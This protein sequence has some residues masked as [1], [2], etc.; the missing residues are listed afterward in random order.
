MVV[1]DFAEERQTII[2]GAGPGGYVAA[3]R[4][5][6]LGQKVM[7]VEREHIGGVCLNVGCIPSKALISAGHRYQLAQ[8]E[9]FGVALGDATLDFA[10]TQDWKQNEVIN[11][12]TGGVEMLLKKHKVEIVRGEVYMHDDHTLRVL[13]ETSETA[14]QTYKFENLIL[15]TGS[16]PIEIPNFKFKGRVL[17]STGALA[18]PEVPKELV[19]I[20]GGYI[21]AELAG[22]YANL[23][24]HVTILEGSPAILPNFEKD[25]VDVVKKELKAKGID[26]HTK[27]LAKN[28]VQ[29]DDHVAV[30]YEIDGKEET[31]NADYCLVTVGRRP[32]TDN[33]G[34]EYT[35]VKIGEK[36][37]LEVDNQ[38]RTTVP[39]IYAI[40]D[41]VPG[42][43]L[44][45][46]AFFEAK[47]AASAISGDTAAAVD[48]LGIPAVCFTDPE[49][50][51]VGLTVAEA[52]DK[53]LKAKGYKFP[54]AGNGRAMT[55]GQP[56]GFVRIVT[57]DQ[58]TVLG[59]Q[60]VGPGASDLIAELT[61]AVNSAMNI[62]DVALTIHAHPTLAE[63]IGEAADAAIGFPTHM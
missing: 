63:V 1:G 28:A 24:A 62:E 38:G 33:M 8:S 31:I 54:F 35:G 4:A 52:K 53:G 10:K 40:G 27:A 14:A 49:L 13:S 45:H 41:I 42:A 7:I 20:G 58:G 5:A 19:V 47:V 6:E 48:Y 34:L 17:D 37:L 23:G 50:A 12:L 29:T 2:V 3:I 21:G 22:A 11:R 61:L 44:A 57:D 16:R 55:L 46:K 26:I 51:T 9:M 60:I 39:N 59:G 30:T 18:L 56:E 25:M 43:A 36:G 15:A 32:N